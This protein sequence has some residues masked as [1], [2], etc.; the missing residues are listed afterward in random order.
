MKRK[1][2]KILKFIIFSLSIVILTTQ[3]LSIS[4]MS[5]AN[6]WVPNGRAICTESNNQMYP[7]I[8]DDGNGGAIIVW[9]DYRSGLDYDIYA[10]GVSSTGNVMWIANGTPIS[11]ANDHQATPDVC[12]DGGGGA[13]ITWNDH[14]NG[15]HYDIYT[16]RINSTGGINWVVNGAAI[17]T[18]SN[19]QVIPKICSD[20]NEG[21]IIV[22]NDFRSGTNYDIYAQRINSTGN[23][24][25]VGNGTSIC[26]ENGVQYFPQICSDGTGGAIII[27][28]DYRADG[29]IYAQRIN[30]TGDVK[31][32]SNGIE[33]CTAITE[34]LDPQLCS[35]GNGGA[36]ITWF[37][38]RSGLNYDIYA[39]RIKNV[40]GGRVIPLVNFYLLFTI[41]SLVS[42]IILGIYW[43]FHK[44]KLQAKI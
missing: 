21:A 7:K 35:D 5:R 38:R 26:I 40:I 34:Q 41:I 12:S 8:C 4:L 27:W 25:W 1:N 17:C 30:S 9:S 10:Q 20:G 43:I 31:W 14:R 32:T 36:I 18:M 44:S 11:T 6:T 24:K 3:M 13:I 37:D 2:T 23:V 19:D 33:I 39:Q 28:E 42:L 22:W 29:D 16:Q 15:S